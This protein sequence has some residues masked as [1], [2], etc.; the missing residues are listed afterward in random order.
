MSELTSALRARASAA[1]LSLEIANAEDD[2]HLVGV[3]L[4]ELDSLAR[5]ADEH[6]LDVPELH[7]YRRYTAVSA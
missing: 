2:D 3:R 4:G 5:T 6:G 1:L 7:G